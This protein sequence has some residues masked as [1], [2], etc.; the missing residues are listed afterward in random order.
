MKTRIRLLAVMMFLMNWSAFCQGRATVFDGVHVLPMDQE[1]VLENVTVVVR[2]GVISEIGPVGNVTF[3]AGSLQIDARGKYLIPGLIDMHTHLFSDYEFPDS[4]AKDEL[5]I[6]LANGITSI[7]LMIGTPEQLVL[8]EQVAKGGLHGPRMYV[9]SP[10]ISGRS[11]GA[12]FNGRV[13]TTPEEARRAVRDFKKAGYDFIKLTF[14]ISL[15][16][17]EAV[18]ETAKEVG[19]RVIGHVDPQVGLTRALEAGQ[20]VEH[21]DGYFEAV[22]ADNAPSKASVSGV[23][24]WRMQNWESLDH[25]DERKILQVASATAKAGVWSCPTL[26]FLK[27]AFGVGQSDEEIQTRPDYAFLPEK[28]RAEMEVPRRRFW[29]S[30]PSEARRATY[31]GVRN[32]LVKAIHQAGGKIMAGSDAPEWYLLYGYTLH[33]EIKNLVEAGLTPYAAL[34]AATRNPAEFLNAL[35]EIGT[36]EVGKRADLV[37]LEGNP[38]T[39]IS[40]T[41]RSAG[42]MVGGRWMP[43][44]ELDQLLGE[45]APRFQAAFLKKR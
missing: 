10:Q 36:V 45:I 12:I 6:M 41:E 19:I 25:I 8:R 30:P 15:P 34:E 44:A 43:K 18:I 40:N 7:R 37:L 17:Y 29:S 24:V 31:V 3:P 21:L 9:A 13:V 27:L 4:L 39:D 16:V 35:G 11:F 20:Q 28:L 5:A 38:L 2:N 23:S 42:V 32:K 1:R 26:T 33:R 14:F 22:I